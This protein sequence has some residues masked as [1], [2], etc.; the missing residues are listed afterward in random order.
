[1][2]INDI[3]QHDSF[4]LVPVELEAVAEYL[5]FGRKETLKLHFHYLKLNFLKTIA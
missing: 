1:M 2:R 5:Q 4:A 3:R